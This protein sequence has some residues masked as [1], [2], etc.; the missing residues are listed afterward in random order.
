MAQG[1]G[2]DVVQ[3]DLP[4]PPDTPSAGHRDLSGPRRSEKGHEVAN[5]PL[6]AM[7]LTQ[8]VVASSTTPVL[9]LDGDFSVLV[10]SASFCRAFQ[11]DP[12]RMPSSVFAVGDGEWDVPQLRSLLTATMADRADIEAYE[13][14][15]ARI[16]QAPRRLVLSAQKLDYGDP[17]HPRLM[18]SV[19]DVTERRSEDKAKNDLARENASLLQELQ[20]R[21]ANSLQII[22]S[23]L[24]MSAKRVQSD[25][26][27]THLYDA[28]QRVMSVASVQKQLAASR[29]GDVQLRPY[30]TDLCDSIGASMI[31][32]R[33]E[34]R[35]AVVMDDSDTRAAAEAAMSMGLVVTELVI[36]ALK[37]AFPGQR[38]GH[39]GVAYTADGPD[40]LLSVSD[41][42]VG[43]PKD[44]VNAP[45]GLGTSIV[46]ALAQQLRADVTVVDTAPGTRVEVKHI[47]AKNT[48][49]AA[50]AV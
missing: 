12:L 15:L 40:W 20:H 32:N 30:F 5:A 44:P 23:V 8:A 36:N 10:A 1:I 19:L 35:L 14:E 16:G 22:A 38:G 11:V 27:R 41:D 50:P 48:V 39:I 6:V 26:T 9:L 43:F 25:E 18:L 42:G 4:L 31:R 2:W 29:K 3:V 46:Q 24:L 34:L 47:Q 49:P 28:H 13:M 17:D 7:N 21:V 45:A 33:K 37:H